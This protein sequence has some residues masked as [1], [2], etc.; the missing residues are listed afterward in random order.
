MSTEI[1]LTAADSISYP[2]HPH[3]YFSVPNDRIGTMLR[4]GEDML[5]N[6][7][8]TF[9]ALKQ[10]MPLKMTNLDAKALTYDD[11]KPP[12]ALLPPAALREIALVQ[13]YGKKKYGNAY[14]YLSGMEVN[15]N[16]SCALR[17]I[18][19]YLE[20]IDVD[21]ESH[22]HH[23]AH[24][25]CRLMFTLQNIKDGTATDDRFDWSKIRKADDNGSS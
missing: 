2:E 18:F 10:S 13:A 9:S 22:A 24:A 23:L 8:E 11:G 25:A 3:E 16:V 15:R 14:N 21:R 1:T 17:H 6:S 20:G 4:P 12:M 5:H 19:D 7:S